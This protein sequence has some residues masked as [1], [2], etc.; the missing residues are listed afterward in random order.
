MNAALSPISADTTEW[1][2]INGYQAFQAAPPRDPTPLSLA[3]S[4]PSPPSPTTKDEN[5]SSHASAS[6]SA[7]T[8]GAMQSNTKSRPLDNPSPPSSVARSSDGTGLYTPL[9]PAGSATG[10]PPY[11]MED[12]LAEHYRVLSAFL[13]P[14][15][16]ENASDPRQNRARDKLLRLTPVQFQELSTD[17]YDELLRREDDRRRPGA[18]NQTPKYLLP[19]PTFHV[20]RNQA[21]QKLSTLPA[22]RFRQLAT[23]VFYELERRYPKFQGGVVHGEARAASRAG[24]IAG[25]IAGSDVSRG[26]YPPR[27]ASRGGPGGQFGPPPGARPG[28]GGMPPGVQPGLDSPNEFGRPLPKTFQSNMMVPNKGMLVED[29]DDDERER[30]EEWRGKI[31]V[32]E[33]K[34]TDL[35]RQ[36]H[37]KDAETE[38]LGAQLQD[39][40]AQLQ[41]ADAEVA[42]YKDAATKADSTLTAERASFSALSS[43]LEQKL[44]EAASLNANLSSELARLRADNAA[45]EAELKASLAA[46]QAESRNA[47]DLEAKLAS[48]TKERDAALAVVP[49]PVPVPSGSRDRGLANGSSGNDD[50][51]WPQRYAE[52]QAE[53]DRQARLTEDVRRSAAD[54]LAEMRAL[55][56]A[57]DSVLERE[58]ERGDLV[59]RL[60]DEVRAWRERVVRVRAVALGAGSNGVNGV[61]GASAKGQ[62]VI[63]VPAF[64]LDP[65]VVRPGRRRTAP[66]VS[67]HR[68]RGW[69]SIGQ[70]SRR[71]GRSWLVRV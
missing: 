49:V 47:A 60:E 46:A 27:G 56:M 70:G 36:L 4:A 20:K 63:D 18:P 61:N 19:K 58:E 57:A 21:R 41:D 38:K 52:L 9:T 29:D 50:G 48:V 22:D 2:P 30:E 34:V 42:R 7:S 6:T 59:G 12:A 40:G 28:F 32:L 69:R 17:V 67:G 23:D 5:S 3:N 55:A 8:D 24:S 64:Q 33:D 13:A 35:E 11:A 51:D 43:S 39:A 25:S 71:R 37:M 53:L 66:M 14:Y 16:L 65:A 10:R 26:G 54:S 45:A 68:T 44:A 15:L 1:S 62:D 31:Q